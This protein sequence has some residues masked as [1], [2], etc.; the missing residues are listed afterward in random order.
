M[1][2]DPDD[3]APEHDC[4]GDK[5]CV[6]CAPYLRESSSRHDSPHPNSTLEV[7]AE[8]LQQLLLEDGFNIPLEDCVDLV[9]AETVERMLGKVLDADLVSL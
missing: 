1:T 4:P 2:I 5:S 9:L 3:G 6:V 8:L 7:R